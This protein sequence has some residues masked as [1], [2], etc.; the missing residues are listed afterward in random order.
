MYSKSVWCIGPAVLHL[1]CHIA[2]TS[3]SSVQADSPFLIFKKWTTIKTQITIA[4][5]QKQIEKRQEHANQLRLSRSPVTY[6]ENCVNL[7]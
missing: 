4:N 2:L 7:T 6:C 3:D 1:D 5:E